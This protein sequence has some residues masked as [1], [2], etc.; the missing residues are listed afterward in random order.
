MNPLVSFIIPY[1]NAGLT[2]QETVD[3]IFNQSYSNF[4]IWI[5]D[6]GSNDLLSIEKLKDFDGIDKIK[7]LHQ[8][9]QGPS[10]ARNNAITK[11]QADFF[12]FLDSDDLIEAETLIFAL[13]NI[14][15]NDVLFGDCLYFGG[16]NDVKKQLLPTKEQILVGNPIAICALIRS[17]TVKQILFDT[18]LDKLGLEDWE[19]WINL[20][21]KDCKFIYFEEVLFKI[22]VSENSRTFIV[23]NEKHSIIK[24]YI[25]NKHS[26]FLYSQYLNVFQEK[27]KLATLIDFKIGKLVLYPYRMVK[28]IFKKK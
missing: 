10:S 19:L 8:E 22:R 12:V 1:F 18:H 27:K 24:K 16:R 7:L 11:S 9:N 21:S 15:I 2:I 3:S 23:A 17:E 13:E 5:I 6:D 4:D 14:K 26:E 28:Q 25:F 20:F